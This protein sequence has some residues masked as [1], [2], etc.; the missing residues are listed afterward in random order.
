MRWSEYRAM[1]PA[2]EQEQLVNTLTLAAGY[3]SGSV[4]IMEQDAATGEVYR[5]L[6]ASERIL[7]RVSNI[8]NPALTDVRDGTAP[9]LPTRAQSLSW[10]TL[11]RSRPPHEVSALLAALTSAT[12]A[13]LEAM[14]GTVADVYIGAIERHLSEATAAIIDAR[15]MILAALER[16]EEGH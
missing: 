13:G 1:L 4:R 14:Q 9:V 2:A 16:H 7:Q 5:S 11:L 6:L 3:L 12:Q 15:G 10:Q 8:L